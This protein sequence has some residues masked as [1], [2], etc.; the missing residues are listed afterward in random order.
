MKKLILVRQLMDDNVTLGTLTLYS[1]KHQVLQLKTLE[2]PWKNNTPKVSCI[3]EGRYLCKYEYST[4][5]K[6]NLYELKGVPGRS[7][8]KIHAA[9]YTK[10]LLGC[11]AVGLIYKDMNADGIPDLGNSS[12]ALAKLHD[13]IFPQ[14]EIYI[15]IVNL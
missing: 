13:A 3:P 9:N 14:R 8:V 15:T 2:L 4:A 11:I 6:K 5:F 7:E 10:E 1:D 12:V